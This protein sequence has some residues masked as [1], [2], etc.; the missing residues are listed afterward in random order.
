MVTEVAKRTLGN[1][2]S[3][4]ELTVK[5]TEYSMNVQRVDIQF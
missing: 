3:F 5:Q 2:S 1:V 4:V